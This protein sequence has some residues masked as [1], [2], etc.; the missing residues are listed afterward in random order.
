MPPDAPQPETDVSV[1]DE[2]L[3]RVEYEHPLFR[4]IRLRIAP[5]AQTQFHR[6]DVDSFFC[7]FST[8]RVRV[9][10]ARDG[11]RE[12]AVE[13][14]TVEA[15]PY[16]R[17]PMVRRII[18]IGEADVHG[19]D[20][21]VVAHAEPR[22][23]LCNAFVTGVPFLREVPCFEKVDDLLPWCCTTPRRVKL[24]GG[25][26]DTERVTH[27]AIGL[28]RLRL[29]AGEATPTFCCDQPR[30]FIWYAAGDVV[31]QGSDGTTF[32]RRVTAGSYAFDDRRF[33]GSLRNAGE[34]AVEALVAVWAAVGSY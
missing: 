20:V 28:Y 16:S 30:L 12:S 7:L 26:Y 4:V 25:G 34:E 3:H 27:G 22:C 18:N 31:V 5:G 29:A 8:T 21:E 17:E 23:M 24:P 11:V 13:R 33:H 6:R 10:T 19:L 2:P 15:T 1:Y 32:A 9:E 14:M